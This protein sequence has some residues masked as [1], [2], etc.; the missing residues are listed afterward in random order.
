MKK[1]KRRGCPETVEGDDR[2]NIIEGTIA[3]P[4]GY[5]ADGL[6]CGIRKEKK[7]LGWIVSTVPAQAA[8]VYTL[9][10]VKAAPIL[11]TKEA[12]LANSE[13]QAVIV[14]SGIANACTGKQ[15][16]A[17]AYETQQLIAAKLGIKS[18]QVAVAS[19]GVIGKQL[20][21]T[22]VK[23]G[24]VQL[25]Q[26]NQT[27]AAFHE[28]ILTTDTGTK[29]VVVT[30]EI[31]GQLVTMAGVAKGS[32]MIHPNMA[33]MLSFI[34]TD[35]KIDAALLS[36]LLKETVDN[37]YNQITV[38]GDTSTNDMVLVMANG[39]AD[40]QEIIVNTEDY[41]LFKK[42][43]HFVAEVLA[44]K[45]AQDG[46]GAT[47]L[48][49]V[50]VQHGQTKEAARL[51]AKKIVGSSLVKSAMFGEDPNWG[52]IICAAGYAG[53]ELE[54]GDVDIFLGSE[55]VLKNGE[56]QEYDAAKVQEVL[57]KESILIVVDL[58]QGEATGVAWGCD[59]TYKYV[60]INACYHT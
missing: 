5:Y 14:N 3:S 37:T 33:T 60:E 29:E 15:G 11:V 41:L 45:V 24:I 48:I 31:G 59:L 17:A 9:N 56:P 22:E 46:E 38:D 7:D 19:T 50:Q 2:M 35:A 6:H 43:F 28:A 51:I 26:D 44:K 55:Q 57:E 49:E 32:G 40:N 39:C 53:P 10:H 16:L 12:L 36:E 21:M 13:L 18:N 30:A 42:L 25:S 23:Q 4:K 52:R 27:P 54:A 1:I 8:A 20:S 58:K 47:K 34:T